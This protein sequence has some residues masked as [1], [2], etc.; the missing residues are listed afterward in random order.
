MEECWRDDGFNFKIDTA[1][2][3]INYFIRRASNLSQKV[4]ERIRYKKLEAKSSVLFDEFMN[5]GAKILLF[6]VRIV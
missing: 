4:R 5:G 3:F 1:M 6:S 2:F